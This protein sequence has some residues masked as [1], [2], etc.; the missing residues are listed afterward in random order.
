MCQMTIE[1]TPRVPLRWFCM[2]SVPVLMFYGRRPSLAWKIAS[3]SFPRAYREIRIETF[4]E[5]RRL[6]GC[7]ARERMEHLPTSLN[8]IDFVD[9]LHQK[10]SIKFIRLQMVSFMWITLEVVRHA[11][12]PD[13]CLVRLVC[14]Q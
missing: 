10:G 4:L 9:A 2:R 12:F 1:K 11:S 6:R 13:C 7:S 5:P 8:H 3:L 14:A